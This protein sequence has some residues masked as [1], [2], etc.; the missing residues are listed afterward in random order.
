MLIIPFIYGACLSN[1][2]ATPDALQALQPKCGSSDQRCA[3][4]NDVNRNPV[5]QV[6]EASFSTKGLHESRFPQS[7]QQV[8]RDAASDIDSTSR[9][10]L[11]R[12][13]T[14]FTCQNRD[15]HFNR[16]SAQFAWVISINGGFNNRLRMIFSRR[17]QL[18]NFRPLQYL[19][20]IAQKFVN[21][22]NADSRTNTLNPHVTKTWQQICEQANLPLVG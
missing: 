21:I 16:G 14:G 1:F 10:N 2:R 20:F 11:Q 6:F 22:G 7:G 19:L 3:R 8:Q 13:I 15:K 4:C 18:S 17:N 12:K 9:E 5:H